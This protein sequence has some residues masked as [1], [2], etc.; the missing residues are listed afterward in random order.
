MKCLCGCN[1]TIDS[2]NSRGE[3]KRF[4]SNVHKQRY[5]RRVKK[6]N[7]T[8]TQD[9]TEKFTKINACGII[10]KIKRDQQCCQH[11]LVPR[12]LNLIRRFFAMPEVYHAY[13]LPL[14]PTTKICCKCE[15]PTERPISEFYKCS[16]SRDG[17]H[18]YCIGCTKVHNRQYRERNREQLLEKDRLYSLTHR[19]QR[20]EMVRDW[21]KRH[22]EARKDE[23]RN[24]YA[25]NIEQERERGKRYRELNKEKNRKRGRE[26]YRKNPE[27]FK[28]AYHK[29]RA[30]KL[31][32]GGTYTPQQW[33]ELC[34]YYNYTCLCCMRQDVKLTPD[35]VIPLCKNGS[36]DIENIQPLCLTCNKS[37]SQKTTDY[38][39]KWKEA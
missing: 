6:S 24:Y 19:D 5:Y 31:Q 7:V 14:F 15:P 25:N 10:D 37:K 17:L 16:A 29:R 33:C 38:R 3:S 20:V 2:S 22:P 12:L 18:A 11:M 36:N 1:E 27:K 35:H 8:V 26:Y 9:I 28:P 32:N 4:I 23:G 39:L 21:R 13:Q 30:R 34:R